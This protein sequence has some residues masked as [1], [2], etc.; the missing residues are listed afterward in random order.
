MSNDNNDTPKPLKDFI[1]PIGQKITEL[2]WKP[3]FDYLNENPE[4]IKT[5]PG[6][7]LKKESLVFYF[8]KTHLAIEYYGPERID[9]LNVD[10]EFELRFYDYTR[11]TENFIE[12]IIGFKFD[13]SAGIEFPLPPYSEDLILP[14]NKGFDKL[15][16]LG[17]NFS[18]QNAIVGI[19]SGNFFIPKGE[20]ARMVNSRF[21]DADGKGLKTRH[22]KWIDFIPLKLDE[23]SDISDMIEIDF[24]VYNMNVVKHDAHYCFPLPDDNDYRFS[25]LPKINRFIEKIGS[26]DST[27]PQI[28]SFLSSTENRFILLMAFL[29]KDIFPEVL[30]EWQSEDKPDI[31]PDFFVLRANGYADI[32]EFK[33]PKLKSKT[34]TGRENRETLSA[35]INSYIS[36]T[37]KYK[38]YFNDPNNRTWVEEK[39][40]FKV[41]K[42]R[43]ILILGRRWNF[44]NDE[45]KEIISE[46]N[47]IEIMNY[48][49]L[50]DGVT[51]QFYN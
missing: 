41:F 44:D 46:Y 6:F 28:T 37:R 19:N 29:A 50:I 26:D 35:E 38:E 16:E 12:Q 45:W 22:I 18:A 47:D 3:L 24:G 42:P 39:Y 48:D 23:T 8:G 5:F 43:R 51:A 14:T 2:Y 34:I 40:G 32:V 7:L 11:S 10:G 49:E 25:K 20:L 21:Y 9:D 15:Q 27:E 30:C 31:K 13:S 1:I 17:W 36:Q 33:L 4:L